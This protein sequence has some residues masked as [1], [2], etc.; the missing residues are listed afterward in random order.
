MKLFNLE[1]KKESA[2]APVCCAGIQSIKVLGTG[3]KSCHDMYENTQKAVH[4][5]G[6]EVEVEYVMDMEKIMTYGIMSMPGLA[7]NE[8][9]VSAGKVLK[10]A[11]VERLLKG[12]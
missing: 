11:D 7:I 10:P 9:V 8:E 3:C 12:N 6:L 5:A 4:A 1:K 2:E